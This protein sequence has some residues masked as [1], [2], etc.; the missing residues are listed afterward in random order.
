LNL[1]GFVVLDENTQNKKTA[2]LQTKAEPKPNT[3]RWLNIFLKFS[4]A[5]WFK[6]SQ[7]NSVVLIKIATVLTKE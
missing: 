5:V 4:S 7:H 3:N 6:K 1:L 2:I